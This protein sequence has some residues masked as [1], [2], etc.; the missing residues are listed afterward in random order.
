MIGGVSL[1]ATED[2]ST[3]TVTVVTDGVEDGQ[4]V[5]LSLNKINYTS[6]VKDNT[7][8]I[9]IDPTA[10]QMLVD[11]E[12]YTLTA[13]VADV[14]GNIA[15]TA[16]TSF[17]V[18]VQAPTLK[19][20]V[21]ADN[22]INATEETQVTF[23][24]SEAVSNFSTANMTVENGSIGQLKTDDGGLTYTAT[25]TPAGNTTDLTNMIS[26]DMTN[27]SDTAGNQGEETVTSANYSVDTEIPTLVS[28]G[29]DDQA[30]KVDDKAIVSFTFS[31][32]V[33]N[34]STAPM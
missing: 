14:A 12:I 23:T 7:A 24:F 9:D 25:Y 27:I 21:L 18:D 22:T 30:I 5:T 34:F 6:T 10:L 28:I 8:T 16:S 11:G 29:M 3:G 19:S 20:I 32:A 4:L 2:E 26:V 15:T 13:N 17:T 1:N 33:S 31:E